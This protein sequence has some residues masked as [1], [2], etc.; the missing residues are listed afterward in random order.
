[1]IWPANWST[2]IGSRLNVPEK[3][4]YDNNNFL[5]QISK[6]IY[7]YRSFWQSSMT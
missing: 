6:T 1:M 5:C 4:M 3:V 2:E 7:L